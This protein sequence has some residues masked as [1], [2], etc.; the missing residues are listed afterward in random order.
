VET[1]I[2]FEGSGAIAWR[3]VHEL[4]REGYAAFFP[5]GPPPE[6]RSAIDTAQL[7][8]AIVAQVDNTTGASEALR[9]WL[10]AWAAKHKAK[11]ALE[12]DWRNGAGYL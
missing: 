5:D 3:L 2:R 10:S 4:E 8:L 11:V 9:T 1:T 12:E 6:T 7:V